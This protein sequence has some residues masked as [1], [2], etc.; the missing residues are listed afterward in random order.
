MAHYFERININGLLTGQGCNLRTPARVATTVNITLS[1][2]QIIDGVSIVV[3]DRILVKDQST[4]SE[5]GVYIAA[6]GAWMRADDL[7]AGIGA[8]I[9]EIPVTSG[10]TNIAASFI[11][12]NVPG[13]DITGT[14]AL[15]FSRSDASGIIPVEKGGTG[16]STLT[17]G[18]FLIGAGTS[19]VDLTKV[20]PVGDVIGTTDTQTLTNKTFDIASGSHFVLNGVTNDMLV[21]GADQTVG[22]STANIPDLAGTSDTFVFTALA[23]TLTN[24]SLVADNTLFID[25]TDNTKILQLDLSGLTTSSTRTLT[26]PD[27]N[28]TIATEAFV[29]A[30]AQ[31]LDVKN[32]V[33][34]ATTA[35]ITLSGT[36]TIDGIGVLA[37][38]RVLVKDQALGQ[39]NGIYI[40]NAGAWT[41]APD[42]DEDAEVTSGMFFFVEEG[43]ISSDGGYVL[44]TDGAIVVGTTPLA[45]S[46]F[47]GAGAIVAGDGLDKAGNTLSL[48]L[49]ANGGLVIETTELALDLGASAITGTLDVADGG[50]SLST[51]TA[52]RFLVG[53]GTSAVDLAKVVPTGVVIGTTDTQ[54]LTNKTITS[55][56]INQI[57]D[58]NSNEV[59]IF[60]S[61][62]SAINEFT[63]TNSSTGNAISLAATG[64]DTNISMNIV[65]KGNGFVQILGTADREAELRLLED[66]DNGTDFVGLK[67]PASITTSYSLEFPAAAG[68]S[69]QVLQTTGGGVL[70]FSSISSRINYNCPLR[71][72]ANSAT[73]IS[74]FYI[75]WDVTRYAS[76]S[77]GTLVFEAAVIDRT[78]DVRVQNLTAA[79]T[80][81][82][83]T[84]IG[85]GFTTL[86]VPVAGL[87]ADARL[88]IQVRRS[89]AGTVNPEVFGFN[90]EFDGA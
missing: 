14:D 21:L 50:T 49:K 27:A 46:Q 84:S 23:Q 30:F 81:A 70:T 6:A 32:S 39:D 64:T 38:E 52:N 71:V 82:T 65:P 31:G 85:N 41:R 75:P 20:A 8:N 17:A 22:N 56:I 45:F 7:E 3:N 29:Q 88:A 2:I 57:I 78:L 59:M 53:A 5:N 43:T 51:L 10:T 58:A 67:A 48:D 35:D 61:V 74:V 68:T 19:N 77:D 86:T 34:V 40:V 28:G 80:V 60:G 69:G 42:A 4:G 83:S 1:G 73:Y 37:G 25:D 55:P 12:I 24:K 79:S 11:C 15:I 90:L 18:R 44:T 33:R 66:T 76:Y 87:V 13:A 36:Q 9:F 26:V 72:V 63:A 16:L 47:S 62:A 89:G 54:T